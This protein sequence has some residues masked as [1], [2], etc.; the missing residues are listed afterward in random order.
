MDSAEERQMLKKMEDKIGK[1]L[2]YVGPPKYDIPYEE[3]YS[4]NEHGIN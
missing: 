3:G 1:K 4:T 2:Q